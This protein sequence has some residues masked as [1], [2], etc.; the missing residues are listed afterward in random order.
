[1]EKIRR[2]FRPVKVG[3]LMALSKWEL[4]Q[5]IKALAVD[6]DQTETRRLVDEV[7]DRKADMDAAARRQAAADSRLNRERQG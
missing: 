5:L 2:E 6:V 1:M 7:K 4:V 3:E